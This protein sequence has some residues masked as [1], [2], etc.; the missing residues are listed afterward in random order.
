MKLFQ[1]NWDEIK[2]G[3]CEGF[4]PTEKGTYHTM[5]ELKEFRE[6]CPFTWDE[7]IAECKKRWN[8]V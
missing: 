5:K 7:N 3:N 4:L 8:N 1:V 2:Y 6:R